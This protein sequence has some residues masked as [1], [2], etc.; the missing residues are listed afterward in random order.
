MKKF[1]SVFLI[2]LLPWVTL[3]FYGD[4]YAQ[5]SQP[6]LAITR[7]ANP[8]E[9]AVQLVNGGAMQIIDATWEYSDN[10]SPVKGLVAAHCFEDTGSMATVRVNVIACDL[11][12]VPECI[13][14]STSLTVEPQGVPNTP[15][16]QAKAI[17]KKAQDL[18]I[19][20]LGGVIV[21]IGLGLIVIEKDSSSGVNQWQGSYLQPSPAF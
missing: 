15:L 9:R 17:W 12:T 20:I 18:A 11:G 10:A 1:L 2:L 6:A 7:T 19:W 4:G 8:C 16:D 5:S 21:L 3:G 13:R 14:L